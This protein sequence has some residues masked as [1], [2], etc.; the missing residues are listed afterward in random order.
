VDII[1]HHSRHAQIILSLFNPASAQF[2]VD[3]NRST[4]DDSPELPTSAAD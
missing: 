3:R 4:P 1:K 2:M